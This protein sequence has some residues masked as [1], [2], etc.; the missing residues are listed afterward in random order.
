MAKYVPCQTLVPGP[1]H[2]IIPMNAGRGVYMIAYTDNAGALFLK[3]YLENLAKNRHV[4][5]TLLEQS[6]GIPLG[7]LSI[8]GMK[9]YYW[10]VGTHYYGLLQGFKTRKA[11]LHAA[12]HPMHN[13]LVV[14]EVVSMNQG[15]TEGALESVHSVLDNKWI[16]QKGCTD[17]LNLDD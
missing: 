8:T 6:L 4:F 13:M 2:K 15:W 11:F 9:S 17:S 10:P 1:L 7:S 16:K 14:G 12:Q 3:P 5:A